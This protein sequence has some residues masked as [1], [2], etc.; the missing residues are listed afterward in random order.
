MIDPRK[1]DKK[2]TEPTKP[3][4]KWLPWLYLVIFLFFVGQLYLAGN[5]D[6]KSITWRKFETE[7]LAKG[8]VHRIIV[9]NQEKVEIYIKPDLIGK[10]PYES[11]SKYHRGPHYYMNIGSLETF[12]RKLEDAQTTLDSEDRVDVEFVKRTNWISNILGWVIPFIIIIALWFFIFTQY[13]ITHGGR[14]FRGCRDF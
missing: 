6:S 4:N 13:G 9:A 10:P 2:N 3:G 7:L 5:R 11:I 1:T 8:D 12:E 14:W